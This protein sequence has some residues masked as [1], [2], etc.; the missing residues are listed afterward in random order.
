MRGFLDKLRKIVRLKNRVDFS[1]TS[2]D[3]IIQIKSP[4]TILLLMFV[5][6]AR[7][8]EVSISSSAEAGELVVYKTDQRE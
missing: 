1:A 8:I 4:V 6:K 3:Q 2:F 5:S 7:S